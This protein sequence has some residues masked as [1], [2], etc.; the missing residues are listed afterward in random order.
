MKNKYLFLDFDGVL[1]PD[2]YSLSNYDPDRVFRNNEIFSQA[3]ILAAL[4]TE[5]P[6]QVIIS[7]SWRF[8]HSLDEMK[9]KLPKGIA[10]NVVGVT[11]DA[12]IGP[13]PRYNEIK[14]YLINHNK[15][16]FSWRALDDAKLEFPN[17]CTDLILCDP[18]TG[19]ATKQIQ[20]LKKWLQK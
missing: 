14:E 1:H 8:T 15:S 6:C 20:E 9:D 4:L 16:F 11:G 10:K 13:H 19:I 2:R 3:P 12:Y 18:N 17:G 5:Y 7:S